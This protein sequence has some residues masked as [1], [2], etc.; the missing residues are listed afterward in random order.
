D[1]HVDRSR[2]AADRHRFDD[3]APTAPVE[4]SEHSGRSGLRFRRHNLRAQ[5]PERGDAITDMRA[6]VEYEIAG[7][8]EAAIEPIHG[9][10]A[11]S[12][13]I[14]DTEGSG[15]SADGPECL[16]H[17]LSSNL[18][19]AAPLQSPGRAAPGHPAP[20]ERSSLRA[21]GRCRC[22]QT[23]CPPRATRSSLRTALIMRAL[24]RE[25]MHRE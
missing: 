19:V 14:I 1:H 21:A 9:R 24:P 4:Q 5:P 3:D 11:R 6:D 22:E 7:S 13:A 8:N 17:Y 23:T 2:R 12:I 18:I 10:G 15:D 16:Q 25:T 20:P